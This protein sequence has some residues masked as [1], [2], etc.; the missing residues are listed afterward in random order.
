MLKFIL[1]GLAVALLLWWVF[2]RAPRKTTTRPRARHGDGAETMV[3]CARC[4]VHLPR[5]DA[6]A[7]RGLH[8]CSPAHRDAAPSDG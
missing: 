7:A 1:V 6:L 8:Y 2:G 4:G 3:E 5:S